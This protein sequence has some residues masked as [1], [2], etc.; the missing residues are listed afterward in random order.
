MQASKTIE[1]ILHELEVQG[2]SQVD[3]MIPMQLI[4]SLREQSL[5]AVEKEIEKHGTREFND[6]GRVLFA[7]MYGGAFLD[8]LEVKPLYAVCHRFLGE[9]P[10]IYTM[11]TSCIPP[12]RSNYTNRIHRDTHIIFP[13]LKPIVAFQVLLDDFTEDNGAPRFLLGSHK[14]ADQPDEARFEAESQAITGKKGAVNFFDPRIWHRS[15]E[16]KTDDWRCC[17]LPGFVRPWMKQRF[18]VPKMLTQTDLSGCSEAALRLL[19]FYNRP[20]GSWE[21]FYQKGSSVFK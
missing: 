13:D 3:G 8:I 21:E 15:T 9:Q 2:V 4:E 11:T 7:P 16:N 10:I 19:G 5:Q 6:L 17:L 18:D 12:N 14:E 20:P 1:E